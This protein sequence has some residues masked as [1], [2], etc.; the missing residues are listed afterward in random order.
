MIKSQL[1]IFDYIPIII[2]IFL[3]DRFKNKY[4]TGEVAIKSDT[5]KNI[6]LDISDKFRKRIEQNIEKAQNESFSSHIIEHIPAY[7]ITVN[8]ERAVFEYALLFR[9]Y[10]NQKLDLS[11]K[12]FIVDLSE[13]LFLDSTFLGSI[14]VFLKQ[15]NA[16]GGTLKLVFNSEKIALMT[17]IHNVEDIVDTFSSVN[18]AIVNIN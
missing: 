12:N 14:I 1:L 18:E 11:Y 2:S 3:I 15:I 4:Q 10:T 13:T 8:L 5:D 9:N 6:G 17:Q 16:V 7:V